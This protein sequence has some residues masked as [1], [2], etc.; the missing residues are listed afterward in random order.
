M[1]IQ[2]AVETLAAARRDWRHNI[3]S[4]IQFNQTEAKVFSNFRQENPGTWEA[5][6]PEV[7]RLAHE[8]VR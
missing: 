4:T 8:K 6:W 7:Q 3:M 2:D 5:E 1:S